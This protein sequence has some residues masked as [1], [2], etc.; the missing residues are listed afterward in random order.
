M[1]YTYGT[2]EWE[3]AYLEMV[4]KRLA[5]SEKPYIMGTPEWAAA[6]EKLIQED[7]AYKKFARTWEGSVVIH[8]LPRRERGLEKGIY[9]FMDLWHGDCRFVRLVPPAEGEKANFV[10]NGELERWEAVMS[11]ELGTIKAMMQ[12]KIKLKGHLPT[13]VRAVKAA[14]RLV[15][16]SNAIDTKYISQLNEEEQD[17]LKELFN[18]MEVQFGI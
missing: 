9:L 1:S 8:I 16:L 13:I 3:Q 7:E 5:E 4:E 14:T 12:G 6:Y 10:L 2:A 17:R 18:Q 15:E 11:G